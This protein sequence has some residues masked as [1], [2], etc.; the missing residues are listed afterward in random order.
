MSAIQL[1]YQTALD[2]SPSR[3]LI[4]NAQADA[5]LSEIRALVKQPDLQQQLRPAYNALN[6]GGFTVSA[7]M[8][9]PSQR[10]AVI[11][12][13]PSKNRQQTH[14]W[15]AEAMSRL[16]ENGQLIVACA[17]SHGAKSYAS[18]LQQLAGNIA[19]RSKSKCRVFSARKTATF[20]SELATQWIDAALPRRIENHGLIAA[21]G[22]FSWNRPD[23]GSSL[24]LEQLPELSGA[25][26]DLC[27]GYGLLA[28]HILQRCAGV[29][30]IHLIEADRLALDCAIRNTAPWQQSIQP[31]WSDAVSEPLPEQLDWVV[32]N[33]PFHSGQNRDVELG[34]SIALRACKSLRRKGALYLVAN[35]KLPYERLL[36]TELQQCQPLIET[37]GFKV[38]KGIR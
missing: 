21:P 9:D 37:D 22:L 31:H 30:L 15:M 20:C 17:N 1:L 3:L 7:T 26:M 10:Y 16:Q 6:R 32:C 2:L 28:A 23:I 14:A 8:P 18:A 34:Q 35:R 29:K 19:S 27:C 12:L 4:I 13:L 11:L 25:G 5:R 36:R 38:I 24:L 33:P